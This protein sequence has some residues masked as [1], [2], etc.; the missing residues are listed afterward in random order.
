MNRAQTRANRRRP[1]HQRLTACVEQSAAG[2]QVFGA[3]RQHLKTIFN[4]DFRRLDELEYIRLQSIVIADKFELDP[5]GIKH[6]TRHLRSGHGFLN[7][8]TACGIGQHRHAHF[9]QQR[10][11]ALPVRFAAAAG[12]TQRNGNHRRLRDL[13]RLLKDFRRWISSRTEQQP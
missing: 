10:P 13:D 12:T 9:F 2:N 1:R 5:I 11:K 7:A 8:L 3:I 4:Q 6:F